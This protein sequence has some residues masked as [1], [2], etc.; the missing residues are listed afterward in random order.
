MKNLL[1]IGIQIIALDQITK[2]ILLYML[3]GGFYL[4]GNYMDV[5]PYPWLITRVTSWF[6]IVFTW[7]PGTAFSLFREMGSL[8]LIAVTSVII[9]FLGHC[10]LYRATNRMEKLAL[11]MIIAG[12]IGNLTDRIRFG[13]VADFIDWHA[14]G[15]HWPAFNIADISITLGVMVYILYFL[16]ERKNGGISKQ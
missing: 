2:G 9:G 16:R 3:S 1:L 8:F 4:Y 10:L 13:A 5:V 12:A 14:F 7:N 11:T 6:N 15:Y